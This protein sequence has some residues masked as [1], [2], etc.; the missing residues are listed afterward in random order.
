MPS[1]AH[2]ARERE[3]EAENW[4]DYLD[5]AKDDIRSASRAPYDE[6]CGDAYRI[7]YI[8]RAIAELESAK[9]LLVPR[10]AVKP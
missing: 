5:N 6:T 4:R 2:T 7:A 1:P 9:A 8:D 10:K 3:H